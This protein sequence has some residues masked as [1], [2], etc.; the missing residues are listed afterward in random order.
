M[1]HWKGS[2][3]L[4]QPLI[5]LLVFNLSSNL[6][7]AFQHCFAKRGF[8]HSHYFLTIPP[9]RTTTLTH[10]SSTSE[11]M[12]SE[13]FWNRETSQAKEYDQTLPITKQAKIL[14]LT[15]I[16]DDANDAVNKGTL[17]EGA[18]LVAIG[19]SIDDFDIESLKAQEPNVVFSSHPKSREPLAFLLEQLP[20][21]EWI[22]SRSAGI[23]SITSS[24]LSSPEC[25]HITV[26]NAK[27]SFSS[28]LAEYTMMAIAYFA[29]D[30]PRLLRQKNHKDWNKYPVEE[31]RGKTLGIIGYGDIGRAAAT[32]AKAY[33]MNIIALR[34]NP[35]NSKG[36][37]LVDTVYGNDKESLNKLM[38]ESD[39]ILV[40]APL[41]E[42]TRGFVDATAFDNVK[43]NAVFINVGRGP[44]VDEEALIVALKEGGKLKGAAL[45]VVS[46]EPLPKENELWEL[47]NV[48][49]SPHNM[50][51][52]V[53]FAHEA[54]D[55]FIEENLPRFLRGQ[56]LLN[57]VDKAAGY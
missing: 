38:S 30:L 11:K 25:S 41:T 31:I 43:Q 36:D 26:T 16:A 2:L 13:L 42:E 4:S 48:L 9:G 3:I 32:L 52:T 40:A 33:G 37:T 20:S 56:S 10:I 51:Q 22:H 44:I 29:K 39:Y 24:T 15:A 57:P 19:G 23:D 7:V 49:L 54:T 46:V 45:D 1:H 21:I 27:G 35:S 50:D 28:T 18:H 5:A 17:P 53:T 47:E 34:R 6:S 8:L 55:F 12:T 14:S